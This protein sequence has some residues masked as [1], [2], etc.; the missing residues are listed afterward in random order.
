MVKIFSFSFTLSSIVKK[1]VAF[2][3]KAWESHMIS[4]GLPQFSLI[5]KTWKLN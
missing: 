4:L 2:E 1:P 5:Y 3:M